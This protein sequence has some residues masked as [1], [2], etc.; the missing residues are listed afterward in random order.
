V[1]KTHQEIT[2]LVFALKKHFKKISHKFIY[3]GN[4]VL[5]LFKTPVAHI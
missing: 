3:G 5:Q 2:S 4:P 1:L